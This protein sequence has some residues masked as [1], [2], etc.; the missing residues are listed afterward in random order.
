MNPRKLLNQLQCEERVLGRPGTWRRTLTI[1]AIIVLGMWVAYVQIDHAFQPRTGQVR[2]L[3]TVMSDIAVP[4][5]L[6]QEAR[7]G[8]RNPALTDFA[9]Y[10]AFLEKHGLAEGVLIIRART[11]DGKFLYDGFPLLHDRNTFTFFV[12]SLPDLVSGRGGEIAPDNRTH[13]HP[14]PAA[15]LA[16]RS[17]AEDALIGG[18]FPSVR[19]DRSTSRGADGPSRVGG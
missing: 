15:R 18:L 14:L 10:Q 17:A 13:V 8:G 9:A 1:P 19:D 3:D 2:P 16:S 11:A 4:E 12:A 5:P 6:Y 7:G